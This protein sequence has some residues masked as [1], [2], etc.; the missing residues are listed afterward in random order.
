MENTII[1]PPKIVYIGAGSAVFGIQAL[2]T[3][4]CTEALHGTELQLVDINEPNLEI[5]TNLAHHIN[6]DISCPKAI[7]PVYRLVRAKPSG[8]KTGRSR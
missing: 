5:M 8:K 7:I 1:K 2:S 4:M 6:T 3:I